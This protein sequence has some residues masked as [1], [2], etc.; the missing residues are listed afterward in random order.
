MGVPP[1]AVRVTDRYEIWCHKLHGASEF[2][3]SCSETVTKEKT[4]QYFENICSKQCPAYKALK[5][6]PGVFSMKCHGR[7]ICFRILSD[8]LG[9]CQLRSSIRPSKPRESHSLTNGISVPKGSHHF[10]LPIVSKTFKVSF[11]QFFLR[12][13]NIMIAVWNDQNWVECLVYGVTEKG[14][15]KDVIHTI[16]GN[17]CEGLESCTPIPF[18]SPSKYW[19]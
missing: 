11:I 8:W 9:A 18:W 4:V 2:S 6:I 19:A 14:K 7:H 10:A 15:L 13:S 5:T 17:Y 3:L 12:Y 16:A 1:R